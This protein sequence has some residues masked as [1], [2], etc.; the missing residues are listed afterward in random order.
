LYKGDKSKYY[1]WFILQDKDTYNLNLKYNESKNH[2]YEVFGFVSSMPKWNTKNPEVMDYLIN[3][4]IKWTREYKIDAWR[5]DVPDEI[6]DNFLRKFTTALKN[7]NPQ[8][9]IIGEIWSDPMHWLSG[10][11]FSGVMNYTLYF[12]VRDF[13]SET[14]DGK[15]FCNR[16][17][18]Y[19]AMTP[20]PIQEGM[21]NFCGNHDLPRIMHFCNGNK[22]KVILAFAIILA[23]PGNSNCYYGDEIFLEGIADPCNRGVFPWG[24]ELICDENNK[25]IK[26]LFEYYHR[27]SRNNLKI[28]N[29]KVCSGVLEIVTKNSEGVN[30]IMVNIEEK[31]KIVSYNN[32]ITS[33][34]HVGAKISLSKFEFIIVRK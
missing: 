13:V 14:I 20:L 24:K 32:C 22:K 5:L 26:E 19:Y 16:L 28:K 17:L 6:N 18:E 29:V 9:Y 3:S 34:K 2:S 10:D 21:F 4:A 30:K 27:Y 33:G 7:E 8:I 15:Q 11:M 1:N 12:I 23:M 31:E 25:V